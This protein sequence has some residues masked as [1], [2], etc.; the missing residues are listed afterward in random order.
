MKNI[1][2]TAQYFVRLMRDN[3]HGYLLSSLCGL[4]ALV[5][6]AVMSAKAIER[7][8]TAP[9]ASPD[10]Q[11][12][13]VL[14]TAA[15]NEAQVASHNNNT[16]ASTRER[17]VDSLRAIMMPAPHD[18]HLPAILSSDDRQ[19]YY[20]AFQ[21]Q[22]EG[23]WKLAETLLSRV[24][25][26]ILEGHVVAEQLL[27]PDFYAS[28]DALLAWMQAYRD[29]P[30]AGK[31]FRLT[32][33]RAPHK[34]LLR[35][36]Y[37]KPA[38]LYGYGASN[39]LAASVDRQYYY[40][41]NWAGRGKAEQLWTEIHR[42]IHQRELAAAHA[43]IQ[44]D[45]SLLLFTSV[46][47]DLALLG[48]ANGYL[49]RQRPKDAYA[50]AM[51][52]AARSGHTLARS[53]WTA[54]LSAWQLGHYHHAEAHFRSLAAG[55]KLSA[56]ETAAGAF[57]AYRAAKQQHHTEAA[58]HYLQQAAA[59]PHTFYGI[60]ARHQLGKGLTLTNPHAA[61]S[62]DHLSALLAQPGV[63]RAIALVEAGESHLAER[64]LRQ[65]FPKLSRSEGRT[66]MH[67]G[68]I[69]N[70]PAAQLR[71]AYQLERKATS[72]HRNVS[73]GTYPLPTWKPVD[74]F[75]VDP[76]L[77]FAVMRQESGFN[78]H[79]KSHAGALGLMQLMPRTAEYIAEHVSYTG[80]D[81]D[82]LHDPLTNITL[83]QA[84]LAYL[85]DK[86]YING[87]M[88]FTAAAY[89]A[90]PGNLLHWM[91]RPGALDDPLLFMETIPVQETRNYVSQ[92]MTNYWIYREMLGQP[93][94]GLTQLVSGQW[95]EY[96][97]GTAT[98][99]SLH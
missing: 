30:Q 29:H 7:H 88:V 53:H 90:G 93:N 15:R 80:L 28:Y 42:L 8:G 17:L 49:Y 46:E 35:I 77:I 47:R 9:I 63:R 36:S 19:L 40:L 12:V 86:P 52:V 75:Q 16:S 92:I 74:G 70:L 61:P 81:M 54:G 91:K 4:V 18:G 79:A 84:Y 94:H 34:G 85:L 78:P 22:R 50:L 31:L 33:R 83:G 71:M 57:W 73:T 2:T 67:I 96:E 89:N 65:L 21:A 11:T 48:V 87:N 10:N 6:L 39:G 13:T 59:A 55:D 66:L 27:H 45:Q 60:L 99:A 25:D 3:Q 26:R 23:D 20:E 24:S 98:I 82:N 62:T 14:E 44:S 58:S 41:L 32:Q 5:G 37:D 64:E 97:G 72:D 76:A 43:L 69:L 38:Y 95:P 1:R 56:W 51:R 68:R